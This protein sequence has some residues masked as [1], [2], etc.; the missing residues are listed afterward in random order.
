M[1][2]YGGEYSQFSEAGDEFYT[3]GNQ[4]SREIYDLVNNSIQRINK[5]N[6]YRLTNITSE[7]LIYQKSGSRIFI[8][9]KTGAG[10]EIAFESKAY[11]SFVYSENSTLIFLRKRA[12]KLLPTIR[13]LQLVHQK[14]PLTLEPNVLKTVISEMIADNFLNKD[15]PLVRKLANFLFEYT[16]AKVK[17]SKENFRER[18]N[19]LFLNNMEI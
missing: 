10:T 13:I 4:N 14:N 12:F 5:T 15:Y 9:R 6:N 16:Y 17:E 8:H 3:L 1:I 7:Y 11:F 19:E 18:L 2:W